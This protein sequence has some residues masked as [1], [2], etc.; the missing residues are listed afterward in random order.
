MYRS[1]VSTALTIA[2]V[3]A[4]PV[5]H[6]AEITFSEHIAPIVFNNCTSCH[7]QGQSAPFALTNYEEVRKRGK[8]IV[9]VTGDRYM[10]PWHA[11][12]GGAKLKNERR[13][14]EDQISTLAKWV[15]GGMK[16]GDASKLPEF[17]KFPE[18]WPLGKPDMVIKMT[19]PFEVPADGSDIY[20]NFMVSLDIPED[21]WIR[22]IDFRPSA[23]SVVHHSL[24][25]LDTTGAARREEAKGGRP[26][27]SR[28]PRGL[29][30]SG[31]IGG[32]ALGGNAV[33]LPEGLGQEL[34]K[35]ADFVFST[36][37]H[38]SGK[39]E[40][41]QS[42]VALYLTDEPPK[43][44]FARL[45]LPPVFGALSAVEIP[46]GEKR[47]SKKDSFEVPVDSHAFA[48]GA[49]AHYL[50]KEMTMTAKLPDG[51]E[52]QLLKISEWDFAWQEQYAFEK[53]VLL[54]KG[55]RIDGEVVW[56]NS[57][58]NPENPNN[59][60]KKVKWGLESTDEMGSITIALT[61]VKADD[62]DALEKAVN[63]HT[64]E[65]A[66]ESFLANA[67]KTG[68]GRGWMERARVMFD[69]NKDGKFDPDERKAIKEFLKG[70]GL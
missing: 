5:V 21:K 65:Y 8:F 23:P 38:L 32:W 42:S 22:A 69:K 39:A 27:F 47:Y 46:A 16:K 48:I 34:P 1:F 14:S 54:P 6:S 3:S 56:D 68:E 70:M 58:E 24:F 35:G 41:E 40:K 9:E 30:R 51:N 66:V 28:M 55:T 44:K 63:E 52:L 64:R 4:V 60:P 29:E 26:G 36:H 31:G 17:P 50:G 15:D 12:Q 59:P 33:M 53:F 20:R 67:G 49:H 37:F 2:F 61:P 43:K 7:R 10:P 25:F 18:G 13:L 19:E 45:Q 62:G 57:A 11:E